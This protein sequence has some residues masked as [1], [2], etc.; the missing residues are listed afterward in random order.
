[1]EP[2]PPAPQP[3]T[4]APSLAVHAPM[5]RRYLF[6][7]GSRH[8]RVE[9]VVQESFVVALQKGVPAEDTGAFLRGVARN[10]LLRDRRSSASR[11]EIEI[12]DEVWQRRCED[13]DGAD[14]LAA[15]AA[16]VAALPRRSRALLQ[17]CYAEG[18]GRTELA[19]EFGFAPE[20]VKT[21][22]RRLRQTLRHCIERRL[23]A[24]P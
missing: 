4:Q 2:V 16:C 7:L 5:L 11:R 9:D 14:R 19:D 8:D 22:L 20:G 13:G 15:L 10:L 21:A 3:C 12:A 24:R 6:V 17:R 1:M 23:G 18:A